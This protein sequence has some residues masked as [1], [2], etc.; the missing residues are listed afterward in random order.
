MITAPV[1]IALNTS[2]YTAITIPYCD[3]IRPLSYFT[4]DETD[5]LEAV[6]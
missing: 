4:D 5:F 1:S 6:T 3:L 2:T